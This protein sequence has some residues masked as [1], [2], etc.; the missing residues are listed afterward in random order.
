ML[1]LFRLSL[2]LL[3][4]IGKK[5]RHSV[6]KRNLKDAVGEGWVVDDKGKKN[7]KNNL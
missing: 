3:R 6:K 2:S 1:L 7:K 4:D 5:P